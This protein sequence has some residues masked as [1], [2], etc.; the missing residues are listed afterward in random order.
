MFFYSFWCLFYSEIS[1]LFFNKCIFGLSCMLNLF[2]MFVMIFFVMVIILFLVVLFKLVSINGCVGWYCILFKVLFLKFVWLIS[3]VVGIFICFFLVV[4]SLI[5]LCIIK[6]GIELYFCVIVWN[7]VF[8]IIG[9]LK[10]FLVLFSLVGLGS[11]FF[12]IFII[13][14]YIFF[15]VGLVSVVSLL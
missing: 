13:L 6:W 5:F 7:I 8:E 11:L 15:G 4:G 9:F 12:L 14:L 3:Y 1:F 10:K 2:C